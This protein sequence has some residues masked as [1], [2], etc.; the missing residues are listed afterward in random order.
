MRAGCVAVLIGLQL[1]AS[2]ARQQT[3]APSKEPPLD[4]A[5]VSVKA[6]TLTLTN[7]SDDP[8]FAM[9][10]AVTDE[11]K[12]D[13]ARAYLCWGDRLD[14]GQA[15]QTRL[16]QCTDIRGRTFGGRV[17]RLVSVSAH[18]PGRG[19]RRTIFTIAIK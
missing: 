3:N 2:A 18:V 14:A 11:D 1:A 6:T 16:D 8:W 4:G 9:R 12:F 5:S 17:A 7:S 13:E 19:T 15:L 10:I